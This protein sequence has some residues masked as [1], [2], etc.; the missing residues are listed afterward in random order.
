MQ[1]SKAIVVCFFGD[2]ATDEGAFHES[3]NFAVAQKLPI[4]F[5]CENNFYAIYT[6]LKRSPGRPRLCERAREPTALPAELIEDHDAD[7]AARA[8]RR[9]GRRGARA[10]RARAS[11]SA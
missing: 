3:M 10:A 2:G 5:V 1:K 8:R 11:S 9:S 6:P 4:L 7:D